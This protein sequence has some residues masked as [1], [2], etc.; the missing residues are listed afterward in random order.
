MSALELVALAAS[1]SLLSGWRLYASLLAAGL[2]M[3]FGI[4]DLPEQLAALDILANPW[5]LGIA[6]VGFVAEFFADKIAW[7]DSAWD[8]L[9]T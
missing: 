8:G 7:L 2:A 3:R 4:V 9:H 1:F 5:V 6:G